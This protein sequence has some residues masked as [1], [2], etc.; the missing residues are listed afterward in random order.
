MKKKN[1]KTDK[2]I[3][4]EFHPKYELYGEDPTDYFAD[5]EPVL[6]ARFTTLKAAKDYVN[7]SKLKSYD[8]H[9]F[10][11]NFKVKSLLRGYRMARITPEDEKEDIPVN[12]EL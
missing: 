5:R 11:E 2:D 8:T 1:N 4:D 6:V 9:L 3:H 12:P 7:N 10:K